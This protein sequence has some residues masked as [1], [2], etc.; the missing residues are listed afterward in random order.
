MLFEITKRILDISVSIALSIVFLPVVIFSVIA[1]QIECPGPVFADTPKRVGKEGKLFRIYKLRS[2]IPNAHVLLHTNPK[3][4]QLLKEYK[5]SS[6]KLHEDPRVTKVGKYIR[7]YSIDEV[8]QVINVFRK[9]MSIVGPRPYYPFELKEQQ[10]RYPKAKDLMK[11]VLSVRPGIT[12]AWQVSGRSEVNFDERIEIDAE[13]ARRRSIL[14]D[15]M[16]L[17]KTPWAMLS[18]RG[19]V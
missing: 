8:P 13:Y 18:G 19:A 16:I 14:Y 12:G 15:M 10:M 1:Q 2:M 3:F 4:R 17:L 9:E 6:Y 5:K 7:K 11:E